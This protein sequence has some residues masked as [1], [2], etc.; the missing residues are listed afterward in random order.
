M[1]FLRWAL[2]IVCT[3]FALVGAAQAPDTK[4]VKTTAQTT[5]R[6]GPTVDSPVSD[7]VP[8]GTV[9][10]GYGVGREWVRIEYSDSNKKTRNGYVRDRDLQVMFPDAPRSPSSASPNHVQEVRCDEHSARLTLEDVRTTDFRCEEAPF[11][12]IGLSHCSVQ[13]QYRVT[14]TCVP[15]WGLSL[16]WVNCD[17]RLSTD[18]TNSVV[19]LP[20]SGSASD[21]V[22]AHTIGRPQFLTVTVSV[23]GL[24]EKTVRARYA[25]AQCAIR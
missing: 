14:S 7:E 15:I 8:A 13:L 17:V 22:Y 10:I 23:A 6:S 12:G 24:T 25:G 5:V 11:G 18:R 21:R 9:A 4:F 2:C 3:C 16:K 19:S 20:V 1:F